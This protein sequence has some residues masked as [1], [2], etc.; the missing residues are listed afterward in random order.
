MVWLPRIIHGRL[1]GVP[2]GLTATIRA[3]LAPRCGRDLYPKLLAQ[4]L[5]DP[6]YLHLSVDASAFLSLSTASIIIVSST[7]KPQQRRQNSWSYRQTA[8]V[9]QSH[10][11][12]SHRL[13]NSRAAQ[14]HLRLRR[15]TFSNCLLAVAPPNRS[16]PA[17]TRSG[18]TKLVA[19][20]RSVAPHLS[21]PRRAP[22]VS[23]RHRAP[24]LLH[25]LCAV[26]P[27]NSSGATHSRQR[28]QTVAAPPT[29]GS[30]AKQQ[31]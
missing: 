9:L 13:Q 23:L 7:A 26:A 3:P 17:N 11:Q 19:V 16:G 1:P 29:H 15:K 22:H 21:L 18:T 5:G 28:H 12:Y 24:F 14:P 6:A 2:I 10:S 8:A 25:R 30:A 27:P 4:P 20:P 31:L